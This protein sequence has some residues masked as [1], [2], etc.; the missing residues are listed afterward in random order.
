MDAPS[1]PLGRTLLWQ[2]KWIRCCRGT[3]TGAA[4]SPMDSV[5]Y[6]LVDM[7]SWRGKK[8]TCNRFMVIQQSWNLIIKALWGAENSMNKTFR[9]SSPHPLCHCITLHICNPSKRSSHLHAGSSLWRRPAPLRARSICCFCLS[10]AWMDGWAGVGRGEEG[11]DDGR[12]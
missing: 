1:F 7:W 11:E 4:S 8:T 12:L 10:E 6:L 3:T 9:A 2:E 5:F